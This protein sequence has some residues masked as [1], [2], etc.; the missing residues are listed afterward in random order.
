MVSV[1]SQLPARFS[2]SGMY[3]TGVGVTLPTPGAE[4]SFGGSVDMAGAPVS[5]RGSAPKLLDTLRGRAMAHE[6]SNAAALGL[7]M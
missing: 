3:K 6:S 7:D 1:I 4:R 5:P 2:V